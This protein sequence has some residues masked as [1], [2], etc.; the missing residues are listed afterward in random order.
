M[1]PI[2]LTGGASAATVTTGAH[3]SIYAANHTWNTGDDVRSF[4]TPIILTMNLM[5]VQVNSNSNTDD[6]AVVVNQVDEANV[7]GTITLDQGT[8]IFQDI[9]N[10]DIIQ[11]GET[12][13]FEYIQFDQGVT[14]NSW[15]AFVVYDVP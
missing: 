1:L 7:N 6:G 4:T 2:H 11:V 15:G 12:Q 14:L 3:N 13:Q 5:W 10:T 8:G 9:T